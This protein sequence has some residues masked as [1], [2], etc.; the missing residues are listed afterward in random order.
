MSHDLDARRHLLTAIDHL[1]GLGL[2]HSDPTPDPTHWAALGRSAADLILGDVDDVE[3][4]HDIAAIADRGARRAEATMG[5]APDLDGLIWWYRGCTAV[6]AA[7]V[8][9]IA[10]TGPGRCCAVDGWHYCRSADDAAQHLHIVGRR[11]G[12]DRDAMLAAA[13]DAGL[14]RYSE[15]RLH[16]LWPAA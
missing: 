9:R 10:D 11:R 13:Y 16:D 15:R 5:D 8:T 1:E 6:H 3:V 4:L 2:L 7:A 14:D 12:L